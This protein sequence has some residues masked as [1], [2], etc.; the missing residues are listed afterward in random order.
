MKEFDFACINIKCALYIELIHSGL[1]VADFYS[2][3]L[4]Y[5][6]SQELTCI[7]RTPTQHSL[8]SA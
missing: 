2:M 3:T 6:Y 8:V 1:T 7:K 4:L 5:N